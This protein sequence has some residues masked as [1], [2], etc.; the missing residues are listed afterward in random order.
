MLK[1]FKISHIR[2]IDERHVLIAMTG[3]RTY[4]AKFQLYK[5]SLLQQAVVYSSSRITG[6]YVS[7]AKHRVAVTTSDAKLTLYSPARLSKLK[8]YSKLHAFP[9]SAVS[10]SPDSTQ[11][12]TASIDEKVNVINLTFS[13]S[14]IWQLLFLILVVL[15]LY[16]LYRYKGIYTPSFEERIFQEL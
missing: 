12:I 14:Y 7:P 11:L 3:S 13:T 10:F 5:G 9:I 6:I 15:L 8:S 16:A 2:L 1:T 4:L